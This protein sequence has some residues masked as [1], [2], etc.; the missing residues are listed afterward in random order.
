MWQETPLGR[1]A[2]RRDEIPPVLDDEP[3]TYAAERK[4]A[5]AEL[6]Q[7]DTTCDRDRRDYQ[8]TERQLV[9]PKPEDV[10]PRPERVPL[11]NKRM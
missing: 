4:N 10:D 8:E 6:E 5:A 3:G 11:E 1:V 7:V 9:D 2:L